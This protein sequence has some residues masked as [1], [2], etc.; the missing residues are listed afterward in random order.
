MRLDYLI[1]E[2]HRFIKKAAE[3]FPEEN[4]VLSFSGGKDS[5]VT[6][7]LAIKALSDPS[8]VHI[9]GNTT[10]EFP[11]TVKYAE[12]YRK[13]HPQAIFKVAKNNEQKL[14]ILREADA[15]YIDEL[16]KNGLYRKIWQAFAALPD[17][18]TVGVM[19][20]E[21]T[22]DYVCALRAVTSTDGMTAEFYPIDMDILAKIS[23]RIINEVKG[24]NRVVYDITSKP[25]GTI[26]WE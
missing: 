21:R 8:L 2:A 4:I 22:Y 15:I 10:L 11:L 17:I 14:E 23:N 3:K 7:D 25:P 5:T 12:R 6:A 19:G 1:D 20:D 9:F 24:I 26:E 13:N 18:K 16:K